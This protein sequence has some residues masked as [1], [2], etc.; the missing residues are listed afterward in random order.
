MVAIQLRVCEC[1]CDIDDG[2]CCMNVIAIR[3][4]RSLENAFDLKG[5]VFI[6]CLSYVLVDFSG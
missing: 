2:D 6:L 4:G 1:R 3:I 5:I